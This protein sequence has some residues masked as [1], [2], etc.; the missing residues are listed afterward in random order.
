MTMHFLPTLRALRRGGTSPHHAQWGWWATID[1]APR[2]NP[3]PTTTFDA[4]CGPRRYAPTGRD[5]NCH[6]C[7]PYK[8]VHT[9][10]TATFVAPALLSS[11]SARSAYGFKNKKVASV[12]CKVARK[13]G[14]RRGGALRRQEGGLPRHC[15]PAFIEAS[16]T[17][18]QRG[19][20]R[21]R[22]CGAESQRRGVARDVGSVYILSRHIRHCN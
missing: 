19:A 18:V 4:G 7:R 6:S 15:A 1:R 9:K 21:G 5:L 3:C 11:S 17:L 10:Q 12:A 8:G 20:S 22:P 14:W 16:S 13:R 2:R